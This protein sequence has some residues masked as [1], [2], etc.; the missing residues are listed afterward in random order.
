MLTIVVLVA[1]LL[2]LPSPTELRAWAATTGTATPL[3]LFL[4]YSLLTVLPI[5]RSVFTL[6]AGLL[7]GDALG[8][9][10]AVAATTL[11]AA[12][13]FVLARGLG[14]NLLVRYL[15]HSRVRE[16]HDRLGNGGMLA[17]TSL[18]LIPIVPFAPLSYCCG[19]S[20]L[21]LTP[22]VAGSFVGSLPGTV[23]LVVLG[24]ALTGTTPAGL[25]ACYAGFAVAGGLGLVWV[26]RKTAPHPEQLPATVS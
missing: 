12:L 8:I 2:P 3:M 22:Y 14:G 18:R 25:L 13:G 11:S 6:A 17:V 23:A 24:D 19:L 16:V 7:V 15:H 9:T 26:L 10:L 20:S 21:R 5:P 1:A 4:A